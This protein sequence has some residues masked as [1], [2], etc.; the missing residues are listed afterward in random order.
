M[1]GALEQ[2]YFK[3]NSDLAFETAK[4]AKKNGVK[5]FV[6]MSTVKLYLDFH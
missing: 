5:H 4:H 3:V 6:F 2:E 1:K